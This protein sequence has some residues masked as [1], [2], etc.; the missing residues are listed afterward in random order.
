[1]F[2]SGQTSRAHTCFLC[3]RDRNKTPDNCNLINTTL[4]PMS[5]I[6]L[7]VN[8]ATSPTMDIKQ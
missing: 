2:G 1:M 3:P 4:L 5:S 8:A 6:N 7:K